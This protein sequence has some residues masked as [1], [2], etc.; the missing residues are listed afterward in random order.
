MLIRFSI[1]NANDKTE[2]VRVLDVTQSATLPDGVTVVSLI[3]DMPYA[4]LLEWLRGKAFEVTSVSLFCIS[5]D[6][7]C[8]N[9]PFTLRCDNRHIG[10]YMTKNIQSFI[11]SS[12]SNVKVP[13]GK[14]S[15]RFTSDFG[16]EYGLLYSSSLIF[17]IPANT[18]LN[19]TFNVDSIQELMTGPE[20]KPIKKPIKKQTA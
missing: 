17:S 10:Q 2:S 6:V 4:M 3:D 7:N 8:I 14:K 18:I 9:A 16:M 5:G 15:L 13:K 1:N 11:N 12:L 19:V 20:I